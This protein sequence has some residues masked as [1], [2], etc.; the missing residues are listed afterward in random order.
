MPTPDLV[1]LFAAFP[2]PAFYCPPAEVV[3]QEASR[4]RGGHLNVIHVDTATKADLYVLGDDPLHHWALPRRR[5]VP[6][7]GEE[8][9]LAPAEY[10]IVRKLQYFRDG[11]S[12]KHLR[13]IR[14]V[15]RLSPEAIDRPALDDQ[16]V[17]QGLQAEWARVA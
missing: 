11:G 7:S 10:V 14:A 9:W 3:R 4:S 1:S 16:I 6:I 12:E 5:A 2:E 17:R 8:V 15:L 13:D